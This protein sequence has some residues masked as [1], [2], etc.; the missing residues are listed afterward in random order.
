M[1]LLDT[2]QV[3]KQQAES[4]GYQQ[5]PLPEINDPNESTQ[6]RLGNPQV[7]TPAP[8]PYYPGATDTPIRNLSLVNMPVSVA[9]NFV[10][11]DNGVAINSKAAVN[12][13]L[14]GSIQTERVS[15][16]ITALDI[17]RGFAFV[18]MPFPYVWPDVKYTVSLAVSAGPEPIT[19][20]FSPGCVYNRTP[21]GFSAV[22]D[23]N[24]STPLIQ[25]GEDLIR[26]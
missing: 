23:L 12:A 11:I 18:D 20:D 1:A 6:A 24:T 4:E 16:A 9:E 8:V 21:A 15:Y 25:G 7:Q 5:G 17:A 22:L 26:R 13:G 14:S 2:A 19:T 3:K 10:I